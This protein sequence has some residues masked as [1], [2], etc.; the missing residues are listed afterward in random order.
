MFHPATRM[1]AVAAL[2]MV[3]WLAGGPLLSVVFAAAG[4]GCLWCAGCRHPGPALLPPVVDA[5]GR[6]QPARWCCHECGHTWPAALDD[7]TAPVLRFAGYDEKK[8]LEAARRATD[9]ER[10]QRELAVLRAGLTPRVDA[11]ARQATP[12]K[13]ERGTRPVAL[14]SRRAI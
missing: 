4:A 8:A 6:R 2:G 13:L 12:L 9:L 11:A 14:R 10:R 1:F 7:S 3:G 5:E